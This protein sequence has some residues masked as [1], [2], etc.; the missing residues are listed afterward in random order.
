[1]RITTPF[2]ETPAAKTMPTSSFL[3]NHHQTQQRFGKGGVSF[4]V[5]PWSDGTPGEV[6]A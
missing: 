3:C 2:V 5:T 1:M 4:G 6:I